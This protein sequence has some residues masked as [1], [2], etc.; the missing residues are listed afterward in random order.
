MSDQR[1]DKLPSVEKFKTVVEVIGEDECVLLLIGAKIELED[2]SKSVL[3]FVGEAEL[4]ELIRRGYHAQNRCE[5]PTDKDYARYGGRGIKWNFRSMCE[6]AVHVKAAGYKAGTT[7]SVDRI[8]NSKGYQP[9]NIRMATQSQ[10]V[11]NQDGRITC[12][13]DGRR[14]HHLDV[15]DVIFSIG[16][17]VSRNAIREMAKAGATLNAIADLSGVCPREV[18][19]RLI[20]A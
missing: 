4:E 15:C 16:G 20:A 2:V 8:D 19:K 12:E 17:R 5:V 18:A 7:L 9:G 3:E 10:Q 13:F 6:F 14:F 11:R 1:K